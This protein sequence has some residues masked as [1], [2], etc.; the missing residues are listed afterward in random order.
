MGEGPDLPESIRMAMGLK[1]FKLGV[2]LECN[3]GFGK[4]F[5]GELF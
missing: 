5:A 4:C 2:C 1:V 3:L